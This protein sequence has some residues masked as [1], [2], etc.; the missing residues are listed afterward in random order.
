[1]LTI[2]IE[3][4]N[5]TPTNRVLLR[6]KISG[7]CYETTGFV[8]AAQSPLIDPLLDRVENM[9]LDILRL[10]IAKRQEARHAIRERAERAFGHCETADEILEEMD[11]RRFERGLK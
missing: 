7:E 5:H 8:D 3:A 4:L 1:M 2:N 9:V 10:Q 6:C 11:I